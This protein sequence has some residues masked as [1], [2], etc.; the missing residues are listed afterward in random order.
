MPTTVDRWMPARAAL[1]AAAFWG[2][3]SGA[4]A[5]EFFT[6]K[7]HGGP[8]MGIATGTDG[9]I[10]TA[11]FDNSVG[12]WRSGRPSWLE[13][14]RAAV[15]TVA[16][17]GG[18][19]IASAGDD[20]TVRVWDTAT[21]AGRE[22][23]RHAGKVVRLAVTPDGR[24]IASASWDG[25]A[26]IW[27]V[28]G[29]S[30][31]VVIDG[32]RNSVTDVA[33]SSDGARLYT[34]SADGTLRLWDAASGAALGQL[35]AHGFGINTLVVNKDE[36]WLA[37]GAVDGGTRILKLPGGEE[38][39]DFTLDRRPILAMAY[40]AGSQ[41]LAAG[42]AQGY[43]MV[44]D[45]AA[46]R[47]AD[48]FRA[49]LKGPVWALAFAP[50]GTNIHAGGLDSAM[51]SWPLDDLDGV[52]IEDSG[53]SFLTP[54]EEMPNG[55]RQFQRKC[56]ICHALG[57]EGGRRAGPTLHGLFGRPAGTVA[58]YGYSATLEGSDIVWSDGTI[59]RLFDLGPDRFIPGSKMPM[60]RIA[61]PED[62]ADLI[63][64]L[65]AATAPD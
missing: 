43:I 62:R 22:L 35:I 52:R 6:L 64:F 49:T 27:D 31:P 58:G 41:R 57:P 4:Q 19:R 47:I 15:N 42:D 55:E 9:T 11:S 12:L 61:A 7:G 8:V 51:Y 60:Q 45:T 44:V 17:L 59:D 28:S 3:A 14:H 16:D 5:Q 63:A 25:T 29:A 32:H 56:S 36:T 46:W 34:A 10:L 21:G 1:C 23:G 18:G 30:G 54:P 65:K 2:L 33:F 53:Q 50:D 20:F 26:R 40:H 24:R 37:Y 48:D 39:A 13:G 38:L